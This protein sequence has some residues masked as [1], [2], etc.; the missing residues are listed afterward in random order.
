[1]T[2]DWLL[3]EESLRRLRIDLA[4]AKDLG[5]SLQA[6]NLAERALLFFPVEPKI[7]EVFDFPTSSPDSGLGASDVKA[8]LEV[9]AGLEIPKIWE[10]LIREFVTESLR[11]WRA[12]GRESRAERKFLNKPDVYQVLLRVWITSTSVILT[13]EDDGPGLNPGQV[14]SRAEE[15]EL[16]ASDERRRLEDELRKGNAAPVYQLLF[17][18]GLSTNLSPDEESGRGMGLARLS[19]ESVRLGAV[20]SAGKSAQ[21]GG[22]VLRLEIPSKGIGLRVKGVDSKDELFTWEGVDDSSPFK[23]FSKLPSES[24]S[25]ARERFGTASVGWVSVEPWVPGASGFRSGGLVVTRG[26]NGE[27]RT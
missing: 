2:S 26:P 22:L 9:P 5:A 17:K 15:L 18:D 14:L 21:M 13:F 24:A 8:R 16:L 25:W 27:V 3:L 19:S 11:N 6:L 10:A 1:M 20:I 7:R 4:N 23:L 12:H